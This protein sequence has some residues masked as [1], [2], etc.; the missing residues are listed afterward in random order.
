MPTPSTKVG[1]NWTSIQAYSLA[2]ISLLLGVAIGYIVRGSSVSSTDST[3]Q[4]APSASTGGTVPAAPGMSGMNQPS[5]EQLKKM[6]QT[7]A[8]PLINQ[9]SSRPNDPV[10]L[11]QI[12]NV[13]YDAQQYKDAI[14]YYQEAVKL[15]PKNPNVGTD[16]GT[17]Y[18]YSGDNDR[19]LQQLNTVLKSN[20]THP[21]AL[22]N[23]GIVK[24]QG[25]MDIQGAAQAWQKLL[26]TN[27]SYPDRAKVEGLLA[28]VKKHE[29]VQPGQK[30]GPLPQQ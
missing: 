9:L 12:G 26:D 11:A 23:L 28:Q 18:Y 21:Q 1:A 19:A 29:N 25:K 3:V 15:D 5:P 2:V 27:P 6:A 24:W 17:A 7:Q 13:Y 10:L 30:A 22:F 16:L 8:Q 14:N 20:P 4:S